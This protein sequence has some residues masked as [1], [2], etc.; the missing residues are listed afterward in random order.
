MSQTT[1]EESEKT[2]AIIGDLPDPEVVQKA[3]EKSTEDSEFQIEVRDDTPEAD[4]N[5]E[6]MPG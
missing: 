4:R 5:R 2:Q 1:L 6:T 3:V